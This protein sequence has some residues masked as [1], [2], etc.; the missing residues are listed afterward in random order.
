MKDL[1]SFTD[2]A[3]IC[4]GKVSAQALSRWRRTGLKTR[5]GE[6][7]RLKC[8]RSGKQYFTSEVWLRQFFNKVAELDQIDPQPKPIAYMPGDTAA[9]QSLINE[10]I[11]K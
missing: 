8:A 5:S 3:L 1:M 2:A 6:F 11:L 9:R 7:V 4:P 10:G